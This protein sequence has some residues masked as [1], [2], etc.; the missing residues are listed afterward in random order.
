MWWYVTI[1]LALGRLRLEDPEF[2]TS[3]CCTEIPY[4]KIAATTTKKKR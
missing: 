1:I 2:D 4:L 3:L